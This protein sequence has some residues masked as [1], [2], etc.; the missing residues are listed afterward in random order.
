MLKKLDNDLQILQYLGQLS[1]AHV[2]NMPLQ[3][4]FPKSA[5]FPSLSTHPSGPDGVVEGEWSQSN[6]IQKKTKNKY[7]IC[8]QQWHTDKIQYM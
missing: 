4:S 1:K 5:Q 8:K 2:W 7:N 6:N 3:A